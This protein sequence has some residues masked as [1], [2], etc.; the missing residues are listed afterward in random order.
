[1]RCGYCDR[2]D[3]GDDRCPA[4]FEHFDLTGTIDRGATARAKED[5]RA[6]ARGRALRAEAALAAMRPTLSWRKVQEVDEGWQLELEDPTFKARATDPGCQDE[7]D[8]QRPLA[9]VWKWSRPAE[10]SKFWRARLEGPNGQVRDHASRHAAMYWTETKVAEG[11]AEARG[12][13]SCRD[14]TKARAERAEA[15]LVRAANIVRGLTTQGEKLMEEREH[16]RK[17]AAEF[18][19]ERNKAN[20]TIAAMQ[21]EAEKWAATGWRDLVEQDAALAAGCNRAAE[22]ILSAGR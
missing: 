10:E 20:A 15:A 18:M 16:F 6:A 13:A 5:C 21:A 17:K 11:M 7:I 9:A 19:R 3:R 4:L 12:V 14:A 8:G 1:M 22:A 2:G